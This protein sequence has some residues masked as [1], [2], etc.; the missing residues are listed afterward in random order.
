MMLSIK[1]AVCWGRFPMFEPYLGA[2]LGFSMGM[3]MIARN[4]S[5]DITR[6]RDDEILSTS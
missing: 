1:I 5:W 2:Q 4:T 3:T 6:E